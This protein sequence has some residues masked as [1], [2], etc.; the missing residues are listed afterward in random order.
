[1]EH[2]VLFVGLCGAAVMTRK[3]KE[4]E[5]KRELFDATSCCFIL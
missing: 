3:A 5:E 1:M 4:K 2:K